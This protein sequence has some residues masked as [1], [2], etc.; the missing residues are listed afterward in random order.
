MHTRTTTTRTT[1]TRTRLGAL[2]GLAG[3]AALL[4]VGGA[5]AHAGTEVDRPDTFTSAYTV[6]ATPE[7]V[8]DG[9]GNAAP[10]EPGATGTFDFMINSE[11]EII[12]YDITVEGVTPPYES[13]AKTATHIHE[14]N[15]GEGGPPRLAFANP[16]GD[17]DVLTS[18]GCLQGPFTTGLE[19]D[20]GNDHGE[21]FSL[22]QIEA[23]PAGFS[24]DTHTAEFVP[25]AVRGQLQQVPVGGVETGLGGGATTGLGDP[26]ALAFAGSLAVLGLVG[27]AVAVRRHVRD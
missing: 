18:S 12:C 9:D 8:V 6:M 10:G 23:N 2:G 11:E 14:A 1:S 7:E 13:P 17:G 27:G 22:A 26:A 19:D 24:A 15:L 25:G 5:P 4:T 21:G 3:A 16:E 20:D